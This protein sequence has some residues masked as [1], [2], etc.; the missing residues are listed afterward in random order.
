LPSWAHMKRDA[1]F[2]SLPS[3]IKVPGKWTPPPL[4][5]PNGERHPFPEPSSAHPLITH[6][7]LKVPGK[8][9]PLHVHPTGYFWKEMLYLQSQWLIHS[10]MYQSPQLRSPP[11]KWGKNIWSLSKEPRA[12]G[13]PTYNGVRPGSPRGLFA[14]LLLL[15]QCHAAFSTIPSTLV[16]ADQSPASQCMSW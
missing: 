2:Q 10:F 7:S 12:D 16:W 15:P 14:T 6:L 9:A 1:C 13:K 11:T 4:R 8:V 3:T 5:F